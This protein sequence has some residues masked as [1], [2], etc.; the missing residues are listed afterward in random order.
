MPGTMSEDDL[1]ADL[2]ASIHDASTFF[3]SKVDAYKR[4]L[5]VAARDIARF[6]PR[7]MLG[8]IT[9]EADVIAYAAPGDM[10]MPKRSI[11]GQNE[12][13][14]FRQYESGYPGKLPRL[15]LVGDEVHLSPAPSS[16]QIAKLGSTYKF[17]YFAAHQ[18]GATAA[19][20]TV[21]ESDRA[22]LILRAQAEAMREMSIH[23]ANK[24]V[25]VAQ[26]TNAQPR[27]GTP[28]FL[29]KALLEEFERV[30]A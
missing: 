11:W 12:R 15:S 29:Y 27:E 18:I 30:A 14:R 21:R 8:S 23:Q 9:V 10:V 24:P 7:T 19:E 6:R 20:T 17:Y 25:K 3:D 5:N 13:Q 28:A 4:H 2:K 26:G 1:I 22:L 16:A